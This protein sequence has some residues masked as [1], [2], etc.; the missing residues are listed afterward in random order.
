MSSA[1]VPYTPIL[2]RCTTRALAASVPTYAARVSPAARKNGAVSGPTEPSS[3]EPSPE[4]APTA[5][6]AGSG[7]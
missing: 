7:G 5:A 1:P 3:A 4:T 6:K 2:V